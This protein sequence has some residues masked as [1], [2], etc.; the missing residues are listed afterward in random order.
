MSDEIIRF[1]VGLNRNIAFISSI[2]GEIPF[3]VEMILDIFASVNINQSKD[4]VVVL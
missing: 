3:N 2:A 4:F 1:T